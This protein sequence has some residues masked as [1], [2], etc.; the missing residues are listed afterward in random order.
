MY[1]QPFS[2]FSKTD[3]MLYLTSIAL[4]ILVVMVGTLDAPK[5]QHDPF[6]AY[7]KQILDRMDAVSANV[8]AWSAADLSEKR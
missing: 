1:S 6:E 7:R 3:I 2:L 8:N 4:G 5:Q